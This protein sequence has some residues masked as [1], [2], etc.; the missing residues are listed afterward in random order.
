MTEIPDMDVEV[1]SYIQ[2]RSSAN[3]TAERQRD[4]QQRLHIR[5][6]TFYA[7]LRTDEVARG[8][9]WSRLVTDELVK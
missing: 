7:L 3:Q 5:L 2:S 9:S 4:I 1:S 8:I 6:K